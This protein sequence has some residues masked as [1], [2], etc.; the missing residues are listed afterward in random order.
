[1]LTLSDIERAVRASW[2]ADTCSPDDVARAAWTP[3]NPAWGQCDITALLISDLFGG[4]L[5]LGE[6]HLGGVQHGYHWWNRLAG[7]IEIDLTRSQFRLGQVISGAR[8]VPRP[9]GRPKRRYAEYE[10]LRQRVD[11]RLG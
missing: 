5:M 3:D 8:A 10:L 2:A 11:A 9:A 4:D 7:G 1:M 6:V